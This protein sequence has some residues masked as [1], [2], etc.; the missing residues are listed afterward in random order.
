MVFD[1]AEFMV[2]KCP[3]NTHARAQSREACPSRMEGIYRG[4]SH[5]AEDSDG[6][7]TASA[8]QRQE[9]RRKN[10]VRTEGAE[11][12]LWQGVRRARTGGT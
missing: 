9:V 11:A 3:P 12:P 10:L 4:R 8:A 7:E 5:R 6:P 2:G 1:R